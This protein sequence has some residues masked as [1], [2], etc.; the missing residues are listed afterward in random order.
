VKC[1][2]KSLS[3]TDDNGDESER[4]RAIYNRSLHS[5]RQ[6]KVR[7]KPVKYPLKSLA[8]NGS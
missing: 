2:L 3:I 6:K 7:R 1:S 5:I 4:E 8:Y